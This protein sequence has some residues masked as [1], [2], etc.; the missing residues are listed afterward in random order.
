M[1][2]PNKLEVIVVSDPETDIC[3]ASMSINIGYFADPFE[4]PGLAHF[5]EH[6][7]FLG[8]KK[9]PNPGEYME[10]IHKNSGYCNAFTSS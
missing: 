3:G 10:Y 7:L 5:L 6:M 9:Y 2:L 4:R 8:S 1:K